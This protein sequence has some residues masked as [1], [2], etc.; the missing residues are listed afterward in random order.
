MSV[1]D[2]TK[3]P[4]AGIQAVGHVT[5]ICGNSTTMYIGYVSGHV[6]SLTTSGVLADLTHKVLLPGR[7]VSV[8]YTG[9]TAILCAITADGKIYKITNV[10]VVTLLKNLN[11][12]VC[13]AYYASNYLYIVLDGMQQEKSNLV[14]LQLA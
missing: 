5:S 7:I 9:L 11:M 8:I 4:T 3:L 13:G 2:L 12:G 1:G 10:G 6:K 14:K